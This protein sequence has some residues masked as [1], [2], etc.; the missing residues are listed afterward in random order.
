[1]IGFL[2]VLGLVILIAIIAYSNSKTKN[3]TKIDYYSA[4]KYS[5][6]REQTISRL[7]NTKHRRIELEINF[8]RSNQKTGKYLI[9]DCETTGLPVSQNASIF[10]LNNWPRIVQLAWFIF[11]E[12]GKIIK[13]T[14]SIINPGIEI[15]QQ[16]TNI[17]KI[18]TAIAKKEGKH[19]IEI[20]RLLKEDL[21][22]IEIVVAHNIGFDV[23]IIESEF[24]RNGFGMQMRGKDKI[25]TMLCSTNYVKI[26]KN[27][28]RGWKWPKLEELTGFL[29]LNNYDAQ[30]PG[31][32]D[33]ETDALLTAKCFFELKKEVKIK[34]IRGDKKFKTEDK[35]PKLPNEIIIPEKRTWPR[36]NEKLSNNSALLKKYNSLR[37]QYSKSYIKLYNK[38]NLSN[39]VGITREKEEIR[40]IQIE[41]KLNLFIKENFH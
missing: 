15:P 2:L 17:H 30:I 18:T 14:S 22:L 33:A 13:T 39:V 26:P 38:N 6:S 34:I 36:K 25:C 21:K 8:E 4:A 35:N 32:H 27:Y 10:T 37:N 23:P 9:I 1:M 29:F 16:A 7:N 11:D 12:E 31:I 24:I 20:L 5:L 41:E 3:E 40:L 28:G 19:P